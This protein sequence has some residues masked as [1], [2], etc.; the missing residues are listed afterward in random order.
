MMKQPRPYFSAKFT[1]MMLVILFS[2]LLNA[3]ALLSGGLSMGG[4]GV[5]TG[6]GGNGALP[7]AYIP[8]SLITVSSQDQTGMVNVT[9]AEESVA[10]G[11]MVIIT[12]E[13]NE[14]SDVSAATMP[15]LL[16]AET[17]TAPSSCGI[18]GIP[19]CPELNLQN[20]CQLTA[21]NDG[22]FTIDVPAALA[23][24]V[25][26]QYVDPATCVQTAVLKKNPVP[27]NVPPLGIE[28]FALTSHNGK[29]FVYGTLDGVHKVAMI[30][31]SD[32]TKVT[33][34]K[35]EGDG[36]LDG[37]APIH[38]DIIGDRE[39]ERDFVI[40]TTITQ[41]VVGVLDLENNEIIGL[42]TVINPMN[43]AERWFFYQ[44]FAIF[45]QGDCDFPAHP[46]GADVINLLFTSGG[47]ALYVL[48]DLGVKYDISDN[49]LRLD[50]KG[51][52]PAPDLPL[53][54]ID[55]VIRTGNFYAVFVS[56]LNAS[57]AP[58]EDYYVQIMDQRSIFCSPKL[59]IDDL[60]HQIVI[61]EASQTRGYNNFFKFSPFLQPDGSILN[62]FTLIDQDLDTIQL[63]QFNKTHP[64]S[65]TLIQIT[66]D[67]FPAGSTFGQHLLGIPYTLDVD[68]LNFLV[69]ND[70]G[71]DFTHFSFTDDYADIAVAEKIDSVI[72]IIDPTDIRFDPLSNQVITLDSGNPEDNHSNLDFFDPINP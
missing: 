42:K 47:G 65:A 36:I 72:N 35:I 23:E 43:T 61:G 24:L 63:F 38:I 29:Y 5:L 62:V 57:V 16:N 60:D 49:V 20:Q 14:S 4:V 40:L 8:N 33:L 41:T 50:T 58:L 6:S 34:L 28:A 10:G 64:G 37:Q 19:A 52:Q 32:L 12:V 17:T 22:T 13:D 55:H 66:E 26:V 44:D 69:V 70:L 11:A 15:A 56:Y 59:I 21:N 9:G 48:A 53:P 18:T 46:V 71:I 45:H 1:S 31:P 68:Q 27:N 51:I 7:Q 3:C 30:D 2:L 67:D 39:H 54:K 25:T